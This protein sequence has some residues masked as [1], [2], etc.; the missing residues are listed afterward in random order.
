[1]L[2]S[3]PFIK[4]IFT[5]SVKYVLL[6]HAGNIGVG[7]AHFIIRENDERTGIGPYTD[8]TTQPKSGVQPNGS[9]TWIGQNLIWL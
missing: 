9:R 4:Y 2:N 7:L 8:L 1:M 5:L 6:D 3:S